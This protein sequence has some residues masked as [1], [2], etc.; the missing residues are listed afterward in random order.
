MGE[1]TL[2]DLIRGWLDGSIRTPWLRF[3]PPL[4]ARF[5]AETGAARSRMMMVFGALGF[6]FGTLIYPVLRDGL[7]D[8]AGQTRHL[9]LQVAMPL[10]FLVAASMRLN[11][12][13]FLR[14]GLTL[15][16]NAVCICTAM[17]LYAASTVPW[18]PLFVAGVTV[19]MVYSTIGIQLRFKFAACAMLLIIVTYAVAL[20]SRPEISGVEQRNLLILACCTASYLLLA[21]WR[22]ERESRRSYLIVLRETLQLQDLSLRN[23]ELDALA[24]RD[25][26]TSL[27]NRRAYDS[28]LAAAWEHAGAQRGRLGLIVIDIDRFKAFN[29]FYGHTAGDHCL[30]KIALCLR[31][32]LRGTSDLIARLGGEEFAVLLPG[33][34]DWLCADVAERMRDAVQRLELPHSGIG[35]HGLVTVS[36]G[37]ASHVIIPG[38]S[39]ES[40]FDA[41]DSAL[42]Q[43]KVS[44]RNRVCVATI[45]EAKDIEA[46]VAE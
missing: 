39:P 25:P 41:A 8:V 3:P 21:N 17:Y 23:I 22:L 6:L 26:L 38:T 32:Q 5:E 7:P 14:E 44:G 46:P 9:Y 29:D 40:L 16:A 1:P 24:R 42:Y 45:L 4:E 28:W 43:A 15:L 31:E 18:G 12:P 11:P 19:L 10:G 34:Q 36:A 33:L 20:H 30:Q 13:A 2:D 37:V 35:S 27:A